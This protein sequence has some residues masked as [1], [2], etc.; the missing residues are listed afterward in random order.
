MKLD[1]GY[2]ILQ[3]TKQISDWKKKDREFRAKAEYFS[4]RDRQGLLTQ[5]VFDSLHLQLHRLQCCVHRLQIGDAARWIHC[6]NKKFQFRVW[7]NE[8][9][10]VTGE[11]YIEFGDSLFRAITSSCNSAIRV[12]NEE[13]SESSDE[14]A[15][16]TSI[17]LYR[18][19]FSFN[20]FAVSLSSI[21]ICISRIS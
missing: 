9:Q 4:F 2:S 12:L 10:N 8:T 7:E 5:A 3:S 6:T 14:P 11:F 17:S 18:I 16:F 13:I 19:R 21:W 20:D 1:F 15:C